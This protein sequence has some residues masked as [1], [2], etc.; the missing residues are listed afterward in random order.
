MKNF[1]TYYFLFISFLGLSVPKHWNFVQTG[2][3][4]TIKMELQ[5]LEIIGSDIEK[6]DLYIG[7]FLFRDQKNICIGYLELNNTKKNQFQIYAQETDI[8]KQIHFRVWNPKNDC[9]NSNIEEIKVNDD[10]QFGI[11]KKITIEKIVF[12]LSNVFIQYKSTFCST[13]IIKPIQEFD[14]I[15]YTSHQS[16]INISDIGQISVLDII[17]SLAFNVFFSSSKYCLAKKSQKIIIYNNPQNSTKE[18]IACKFP[19]EV[20]SEEKNENY[21]YLW[22]NQETSS[23]RFIDTTGL[24]IVSKKINKCIGYDSIIVS[25]YE[26][27]NDAITISHASCEKEGSV[28]LDKD[29]ILINSDSN[30]SFQIDDFTLLNNY[31]D[32]LS[33]GVHDLVIITKNQCELHYVFELQNNCLSKQENIIAPSIENYTAF[34][35]TEIGKINIYNRT[36]TLIRTLEGPTEWNGTDQQGN[37]V[38]VGIYFI[39]KQNGNRTLITILD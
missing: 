14:K 29:N 15:T 34:L 38:P 22:N 17:D 16:N 24:Y 33:E 25:Q 5:S 3:S 19:L 13:E 9:E 27:N 23:S 26:I 32:E 8:N 7:A 18:I 6:K 37:I 11:N 35:I 10:I 21:S 31:F 4:M 20:S 30:V 28:D 36:G 2:K 12:N 39:V 1:L